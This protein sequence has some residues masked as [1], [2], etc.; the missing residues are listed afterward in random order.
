MVGRQ[1]DTFVLPGT[2]VPPD[3][4][5]DTTAVQ[6]AST[7]TAL[8]IPF[9]FN[10]SKCLLPLSPFM[11]P[12]HAVDV[13]I[14]ASQSEEP[15]VM[16]SLGKAEYHQYE[17]SLIKFASLYHAAVPQSSILCLMRRSV[18]LEYIYTFTK[19]S[20]FPAN[21][22]KGVPKTIR[23]LFNPDP[24]CPGDIVY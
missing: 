11:E 4:Q 23:G 1:H 6:P 22:N 5:N 2:V 8:N 18:N 3:Y 19:V 21:T 9:K 13:E 7:T 20:D 16:T 14:C 17:Y 12:Q 24:H 15:K 10:S